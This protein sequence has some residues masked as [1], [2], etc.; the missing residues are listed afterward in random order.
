MNYPQLIV[1]GN[2]LEAKPLPATAEFKCVRPGTGGTLKIDDGLGCI[3]TIGCNTSL[4]VYFQVEPQRSFCAHITL[5]QPANM[6]SEEQG[7]KLSKQIFQKLKE[8]ASRDEWAIEN[9]N[10]AG[11]MTLM[12][13]QAVDQEQEKEKKA[14]GWYMVQGVRDF[15]KSC[16]DT[17]EP[18]AYKAQVEAWEA[19]GLSGPKK[20]DPYADDDVA[21]AL[22]DKA[23]ELN[24]IVKCLNLGCIPSMSAKDGH[25]FVAVNSLPRKVLRLSAED[26]LGAGIHSGEVET[27]Q[28]SA[29]T[30]DLTEG[31]WCFAL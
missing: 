18:I 3:G 12:C 15:I 7:E 2:T 22:E 25:G 24:T 27:C 14:P 17:L 30:V 5:E 8:V 23:H 11:C 1:M 16:V 26:K 9:D 6:I 31:E 4:G 28:F 13:Q 19:I 21:D 20:F 29:R 10:F